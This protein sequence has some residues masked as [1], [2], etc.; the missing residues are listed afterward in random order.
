MSTPNRPN[1]VS[2][3][4]WLWQFPFESFWYE[5]KD[6]VSQKTQRPTNR[7]RHPSLYRTA[8]LSTQH[9][10]WPAIQYGS[11][12]W[13]WAGS[14][15]WLAVAGSGWQ[16]LA[17]L[18]SDSWKTPRCFE[19]FIQEASHKSIRSTRS[20]TPQALDSM[21]RKLPG[22]R[23][24]CGALVNMLELMLSAGHGILRCS[25]SS[26]ECQPRIHKSWFIS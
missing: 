20:T 23:T 2:C 19:S 13:G 1:F 9:T 7:S 6:G 24:Q 14:W 11:S 4:C 12:A 22:P 8:V 18:Q 16:W 3:D 5:G 15:Q 10:D 17:G 21:G 25:W 26:L